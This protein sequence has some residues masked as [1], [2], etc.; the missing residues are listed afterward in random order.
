MACTITTCDNLAAY[1]NIFLQ[2]HQLVARTLA[3]LHTEVEACSIGRC[4]DR[5]V[6]AARDRRDQER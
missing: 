6:E 3:P 5:L 1:H 2:T 4:G